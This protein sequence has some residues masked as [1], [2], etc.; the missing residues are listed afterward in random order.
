[1]LLFCGILVE[2]RVFFM[3]FNMLNIYINIYLFNIIV[4]RVEIFNFCFENFFL[5]DVFIYRVVLLF[6]SKYF[7]FKFIV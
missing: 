7:V 2:I 5:E 3:I 4:K 6:F 1:M